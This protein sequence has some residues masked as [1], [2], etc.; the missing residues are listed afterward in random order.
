MR[1]AFE[2]FKRLLSH[3]NKIAINLLTPEI[4]KYFKNNISQYNGLGQKS[5][6]PKI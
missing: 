3:K 5:V 6:K 2:V 4:Y 1:R